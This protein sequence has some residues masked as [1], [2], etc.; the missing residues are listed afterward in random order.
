MKQEKYGFVYIWY[1]RKH[2]RY[3]VG[4]HWG[5]VDDGYICSSSWMLKAQRRRPQ[6]FKRRIIENN[7]FCKKEL[8]EREHLWLQKIKSN[9]LKTRYYN[10]R[11]CKYTPWTIDEEKSIKI[12]KKLSCPIRAAKVSKALTGI[13]RSEETK[14]KI[15]N[16]NVGKKHSEET[17]EKM[18]QNRNRNYDCPIFREKMSKA[19]KNRSV[20][21][22]RKL[23]ESLKQTLHLKKLNIDNIFNGV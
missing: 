14:E 12:K 10:L 21:H 9:E 17:K 16:A 20:E 3:Y 18:R 4:C 15:R 13:K 5:T 1:D 19:A 7:I 11:N 22:Q 8:Y 23:N 6:D 2:K